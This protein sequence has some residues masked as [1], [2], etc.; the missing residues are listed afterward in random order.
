MP[1]KKSETATSSASSASQTRARGS[2]SVFSILHGL[3]STIFYIIWILIGLFMLLFIYGNFKQ[4]AFRGL[5]KAAPTAQPQQMQAP[6]ETAIPG[7]GKVN[8]DCVQKS[9]TPQEIQKVVQTGDSSKLTADEK[10]KLDPCIVQKEEAT[11]SAS[12]NK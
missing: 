11:P 1:A 3:L 12:S 8:I 4:G 2:K 10:A 6:T 9:L 7:I 5:L